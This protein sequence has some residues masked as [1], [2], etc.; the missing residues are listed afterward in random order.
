MPVWVATTSTADPDRNAAIRAGDHRRPRRSRRFVPA[1]Y[2]P[3]AAPTR[4]S[5][6]GSICAGNASV[7]SEG[8]GGDAIAVTV[9]RCRDADAPSGRLARSPGVVQREGERGVGRDVG[10]PAPGRAG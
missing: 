10:R 7:H 4:T 5:A 1:T 9:P 8:A 6:A 2:S 3:A